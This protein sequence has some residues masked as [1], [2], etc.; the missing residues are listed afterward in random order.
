MIGDDEAHDLAPAR[1]LCLGTHRVHVDAARSEAPLA[2]LAA[3]L[4]GG[5]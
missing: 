1:S 3:A 4:A 5:I 2:T